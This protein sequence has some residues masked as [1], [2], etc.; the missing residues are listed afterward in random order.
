MARLLDHKPGETLSV[1]A[2]SAITTPY[3]FV[4]FDT[5]R[6]YCVVAGA[7]EDADGVLESKA[8]AGEAVEMVISGIPLVY[9]GGTVANG[10]YVM[11]DSAAKAVV[12]TPGNKILGQAI[13]GG[14]SGELISVILGKQPAAQ[15]GG[16][17]VAFG[18][19]VLVAGTVTVSTT[20]VR[21]GDKIL[22]TRLVTGGTVGHLTVGTIV[23]ATSFVI[24][25]A[26]NTD[27]STVAW[28][29]VR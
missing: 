18:S 14:A 16:T 13:R 9:A 6:D 11:A 29:I 10:D 3:L 20:A 5:D 26:V 25:C 4:K 22:L 21:T 15:F 7:G 17:I 23:N 1:K 19:A 28:A 24:D 12:A 27:T 2:T 8:A